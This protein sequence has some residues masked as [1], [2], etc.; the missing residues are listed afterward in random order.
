MGLQLN[1]CSEFLFW[2]YWSMGNPNEGTILLKPVDNLPR[3]R[4]AQR[5]TLAKW[6]EE[7]A[8]GKKVQRAMQWEH[9]ESN[10]I[11]YPHSTGS[12]TSIQAS[13]RCVLQGIV[14]TDTANEHNEAVSA[15]A[16]EHQEATIIVAEGHAH[17]QWSQYPPGQVSRW[18]GWVVRGI[19]EWEEQGVSG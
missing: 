1:C 3:F 5:L 13:T 8:E 15:V 4:I 14:L 6:A 16:G 9:V 12:S 7:F 18:W 2:W 17:G 11:P 19:S 10:H